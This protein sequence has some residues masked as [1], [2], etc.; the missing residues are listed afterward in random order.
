MSWVL[1][2]TY[3]YIYR[4]LKQITSSIVFYRILLP[5]NNKFLVKLKFGNNS[6]YFQYRLRIYDTNIIH[7]RKFYI[8]YF[9]LRLCSTVCTR[10]IFLC[11]VPL[12]PFNNITGDKVIDILIKFYRDRTSIFLALVGNLLSQRDSQFL[13]LKKLGLKMIIYSCESYINSI[14]LNRKLMFNC[15]MTTFTALFLSVF[16]P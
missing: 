5:G 11:C 13:C 6:T 8:R 12:W 14:Y 9:S 16:S 1:Q 4:V 7:V 15:L 2:R 10:N 3:R